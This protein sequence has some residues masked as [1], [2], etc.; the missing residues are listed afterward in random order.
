M[1]GFITRFISKLKQLKGQSAIY[2]WLT[3][4]QDLVDE[5]IE[6]IWD[7][8]TTDY[9]L[10][11]DSVNGDDDTGDGSVGSPYKT[12]ERTL[13]DIPLRPAYKPTIDLAGDFK[14]TKDLSFFFYV[15]NIEI[16]GKK[17]IASTHAITG[18]VGASKATGT[19]LTVA[20]AGWVANE[21]VG[22]LVNY[23]SGLPNER[24]GFVY[25]NTAD[26]IYISQNGNIYKA[27]VNGDTFD[28]MSIDTNIDIE[29]AGSPGTTLGMKSCRFKFYY[30]NLTGDGLVVQ[31]SWLYTVRCTMNL[32]T[33]VGANA[34]FLTIE[35]TYIKGTGFIA[36]FNF[37]N[38]TT[39]LFAGT[40]I[41]GDTNKGLFTRDQ[42]TIKLAGEVVFTRLD[43]NGIAT[44]GSFWSAERDDA[45]LRLH[46]CVAGFTHGFWNNQDPGAAQSSATNVVNL[47]P[48]YGNITGDYLIMAKA[49]DIYNIDPTSVVTT[50]LGTNNGSVDNG[51]TEGY[52]DPETGTII[53][54]VKEIGSYDT[55]NTVRVAADYVVSKFDYSVG[56][57]DTT[58]ARAITIPDPTT[59]PINKGF[60]V[61]DESGNAAVNNITITPA[62]GLI[63]GVANFVI[64]TNYQST[65]IIQDGTNY[66]TR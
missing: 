33:A 20:G 19:I 21:H 9:T 31:G 28:I 1:E 65:K 36:W 51:L 15:N 49:G 3:N 35:T 17:S 58:V 32:A 43:N 6:D 16:I 42:C 25:K 57:T 11:A 40:V 41:D 30:C 5:V 66:F 47:P 56:V 7:V 48:V 8:N 29:K 14:I 39:K 61:G 50:A 63:N 34:S 2:T 44:L 62:V 38:T 54:G 22:K 52:H 37:Q 26:T 55:E 59:L 64:N 4:A 18:I 24:Y 45:W 46:D 60:E 10:Y 53:Y 23:T 27:P 13:M 12:L